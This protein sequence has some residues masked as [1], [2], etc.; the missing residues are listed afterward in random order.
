MSEVTDNPATEEKESRS[1]RQAPEPQ[2]EVVLNAEKASILIVG[3][4]KAVLEL[5]EC[6]LSQ[7]FS[8]DTALDVK[9]AIAWLEGHRCDLIMTDL[10]MPGGSG[11]NLCRIV[12]QNWPE[13][14]IFMIS[15]RHASA[16]VSEAR[17]LGALDYLTKPV[18]LFWL[19]RRIRQVLAC[20]IRLEIAEGAR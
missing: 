20:K 5:L 6:F 14:N 18:A 3:D 7:E 10:E 8:C 16:C 19:R 4:D 17:R 15:G 13:T 11:F 2:A 12:K 9:G 1:I